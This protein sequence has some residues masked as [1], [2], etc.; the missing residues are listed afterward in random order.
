MGGAEWT[1]I[2]GMGMGERL[3]EAEGS[4]GDWDQEA[5]GFR[6]SFRVLQD[7]SWG[8][9]QGKW[10]NESGLITRAHFSS[11]HGIGFSSGRGFGHRR[12]GSK[13]RQEGPDGPGTPGRFS[14]GQL[15]CCCKGLCWR[16][17]MQWGGDDKDGSGSD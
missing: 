16:S 12:D 15:S 4:D 11:S 13:T 1:A 2:G 7:S 8:S 14:S 3:R 9:L 10:Q 6:E 17:G 5:W